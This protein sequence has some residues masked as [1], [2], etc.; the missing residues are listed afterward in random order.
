[1]GYLHLNLLETF[2]Q[3]LGKEFQYLH[4]SAL[5]G[6]DVIDDVGQILGLLGV[7]L[8][9]GG[10]VSLGIGDGGGEVGLCYL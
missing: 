9:N 1:M 2:S 10:Q 5:H 3:D 7:C 4:R 6:L 8:L